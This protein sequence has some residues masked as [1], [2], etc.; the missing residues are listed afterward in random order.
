MSLPPNDLVPIAARGLFKQE[1]TGT[2]IKIQLPRPYADWQRELMTSKCRLIMTLNA[3]KTGKTLGG[4]AAIGHFSFLARADQAPLFRII[5]PTYALSTITYKYL[6][7]L[8]PPKIAYQGH[9]TAEQNAIAASQW[10]QWTPRRTPS[11]YRMVWPHNKAVIQCLHA[12]DPETT[13]EGERTFGNLLDEASKMPE[14]V[15][16]STLSTTSQTGGWIRITTTPRGKSHWTGKLYLQIREHMRWC[17]QRGKPYEQIAFQVA[18]HTN[19]YVD[20]G[21]IELA[22]K[23]L[24]DRLFRQLYHAELIDAGSVFTGHMDLIEGEPIFFRDR[25]IWFSADAEE[26]QVIIGCDWGRKAD[27]TVA[28]AWSVEDHPR[29]VGFTRIQGAAWG[30]IVAD[31]EAF[32]SKFAEVIIM[33]HDRTGIGDVIDEMLTGVSWPVEPVIFTNQSKAAMVQELMLGIERKRMRLPHWPAMIDELDNFGVSTT[34]LGHFKYEADS[35]HDDIVCAM[36]LGW[37]AMSEIGQGRADV[38]TLDHFLDDSAMIKT[39]DF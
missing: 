4:S 24:P 21:V 22:R 18:T 31:V 13:I 1:S 25:E 30:E 32:G 38:L 9:L 35:G 7:R 8:F 15:F 16:A 2:G 34:A 11:R 39:D 26:C 19:P 3:T 5:A 6:E 33:R 14:Q 12:K 37:S 29:I 17:E 20:P 28:V 27:Y 10:E 36:F 23:T